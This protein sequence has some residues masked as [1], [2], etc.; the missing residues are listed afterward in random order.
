MTI[1]CKTNKKR[2]VSFYNMK[3]FKQYFIFYLSNRVKYYNLIIYLHR[4]LKIGV[5][6]SSLG[7]LYQIKG[8]PNT[9]KDLIVK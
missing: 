5:R 9:L 2:A 3:L 6:I 8:I 4:V 1:S 7:T